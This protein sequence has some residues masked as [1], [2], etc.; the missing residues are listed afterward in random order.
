[1]SG[2]TRHI[3]GWPFA[4]YP[5]FS[6]PPLQQIS[7][8]TVVAV[9]P[10][11]T[12]TTVTNFGFPYHRYYGLSKNILAIDDAFV[13][14]DRLLLVW[15]RAV[16]VAPE[17]RSTT[18]VKFY[19]ENWCVDPDLWSR[20]PENRKLLFVWRPPADG[21]ISPPRTNTHLLGTEWQ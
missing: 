7:I 18:A 12:E 2:I 10:S 16:Q 3:N 1:L 19:G 5:T 20:N 6:L 11:G 13:R 17:L 14:N 9:A 15:A 4:C 21:S 8:L